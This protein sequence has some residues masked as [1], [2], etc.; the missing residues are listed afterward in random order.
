MKAAKNTVCLCAA[1]ILVGGVPACQLLEQ[2]DTPA[3]AVAAVYAAIDAAANVAAVSVTDGT[4]EI[5]TAR[6]VRAILGDAYRFARAAELAIIDGNP[7]TAT[8][9]LAA[10]ERALVTVRA[11][12]ATKE[13]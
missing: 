4:I 3:E 5:E 8:A 11:L 12:L 13:G 9:Y 10:A 7:D 6:D 1:L 2:P